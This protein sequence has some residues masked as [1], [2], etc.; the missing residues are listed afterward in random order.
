MTL[1]FAL[2]FY[3]LYLYNFSWITYVVTFAWGLQDSTLNNIM[4]CTLGFE[5]EG[6]TMT[7]FSV[8]NFVQPFFTFVFMV[9]QA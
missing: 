9:V 3:Y 7:P 6:N 2:M 5:F 4:N 8:Q 1:A